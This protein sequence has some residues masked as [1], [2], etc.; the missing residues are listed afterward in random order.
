MLSARRQKGA[1]SKLLAELPVGDVVLRYDWKEKFGT[2][3]S[4]LPLLCMVPW[5]KPR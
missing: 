3:S 4:G 5:R 2:R 1:L